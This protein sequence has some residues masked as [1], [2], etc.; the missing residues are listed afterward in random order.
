MAKDD[1][2][3]GELDR[4]HRRR[5]EELTKEWEKSQPAIG[6]LSA[7]DLRL[8]LEHSPLV[9]DLIHSIA[10]SSQDTTPASTP[11]QAQPP[12]ESQLCSPRYDLESHQPVQRDLTAA[13]QKLLQ[14]K[15]KLS[16]AN[17]TLK[18]E[19][20]ELEKQ[21]QKAQKQLDAC[22][23]TAPSNAV[24][25]LTL[26]RG[27]LDLAQRLGLPD[28]PSD[29]TQALIHVVAVLA[30]RENLERLWSALK[31]RCE[32]EQRP[33]NLSERALLATA[34]AWHN[35]NWR[36]RPYRLI[37][38]APSSAYH[39]ESHLR[40]RHTQAGETVLDLHLPGIADGS[41]Q[42]LCKALVRTR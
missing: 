5:L 19:K 8:L 3:I 34:L 10:A 7:L 15:E 27:D 40:S 20:K 39:F 32:A 23:A 17:K 14:E 28:L 11:V 12:I 2:D 29:D 35:H 42:P 6:N 36:T 4:H 38:A 22:Q 16:K 26:L 33:A 30:Q 18:E 24:P 25:A 1:K 31:D 21:L 13:T 37:E 41:G 9:Q